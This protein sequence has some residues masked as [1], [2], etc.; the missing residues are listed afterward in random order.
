MLIYVRIL[1]ASP[2]SLFSSTCLRVFASLY[3][4][5]AQ[6]KSCPESGGGV[7]KQFRILTKVS[8]IIIPTEDWLM[9]VVDSNSWPTQERS[10]ERRRRPAHIYSITIRE[11]SFAF[12]ESTYAHLDASK[13]SRTS[14][15]AS[16]YGFTT[17]LHLNFFFCN[18]VTIF[19]IIVFLS[20]LNTNSFHD[21]QGSRG[22]QAQRQ[23][24]QYPPTFVSAP[25]IK[26][27]LNPNSSLS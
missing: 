2:S 15:F 26:Y 6:F 24:A 12:H 17:L 11:Q 5:L 8:P 9:I 7:G 16:F 25:T 19:F 4:V 21:K 10:E 1:S 14:T 20:A 13:H 18:P 23:D 22:P 3:K 27:R